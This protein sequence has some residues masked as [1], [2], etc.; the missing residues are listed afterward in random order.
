MPSWCLLISDVEPPS[1]GFYRPMQRNHGR[2]STHNMAPRRDRG[3]ASCFFIYAGERAVDRLYPHITV[4]LES[5][6]VQKGLGMSGEML[7]FRSSEFHVSSRDDTKLFFRATGPGGRFVEE[8]GQGSLLGGATLRTMGASFIR[9][10]MADVTSG[11]N[12]TTLEDGWAG[13]RPTRGDN[14]LRPWEWDALQ[15]QNLEN[16]Q[17][18][19]R[20]VGPERDE[21]W[22]RQFEWPDDDEF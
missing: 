4:M 2:V 15:R 18:R 3:S 20:Q 11:I 12:P 19:L 6:L 21:A 7:F 14:G 17:A 1:N 10:L 16:D 5:P 9:K 8:G 13:L 22:A